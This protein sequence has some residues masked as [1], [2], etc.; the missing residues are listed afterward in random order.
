MSKYEQNEACNA[1]A[2]VFYR[3]IYVTLQIIVLAFQ[4]FQFLLITVILKNVSLNIGPEA[5]DAM[6]LF[7]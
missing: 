5:G 4:I 6:E 7:M 3:G 1:Y 2:S